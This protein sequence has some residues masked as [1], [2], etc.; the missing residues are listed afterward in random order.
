M[1]GVLISKDL[2]L[3]TKA[4][5]ENVPYDEK[6]LLSSNAGVMSGYLSPVE[7][8]SNWTKK[9]NGGYRAR[10]KRLWFDAASE[11]YKPKANDLE[12]DLFYPL[13]SDQPPS[14]KGDRLFA[15][16]RG[17]W[18]VIAIPN[19]EASDPTEKELFPVVPYV[20]TETKTVKVDGQ[21]VEVS[22]TKTYLICPGGLANDK[23]IKAVHVFCVESNKS[24]SDKFG[25]LPTAMNNFAA[26]NIDGKMV[27]CPGNTDLE[28]IFPTQIYDFIAKEWTKNNGKTLL[29]GCPAY[30]FFD[31]ATGKNRVICI[32]GSSAY[33]VSSP[34]SV[35]STAIPFYGHTITP[36]WEID[37][38][39]G[40]VKP[41][42]PLRT[43]DRSMTPDEYS[44]AAD[45]DR[46]F[47]KQNFS[48]IP[49]HKLISWNRGI[50]F[51]S[52]GGTE[53]LNAFPTATTTYF[54]DDLGTYV[55]S[56]NNSH[57]NVET[58]PDSPISLGECGAVYVSRYKGQSVNWLVAIGGRMLMQDGNYKLHEFPYV[59]DL[60]SNRWKIGEIPPLPTPRF[61]AGISQVVTTTETNPQ[62]NEQKTS[63]RIFVI[64]GRTQEGLTSKIES[65]NLTTGQWE[66]S[67]K[68]L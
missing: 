34:I 51:I 68:N 36:K 24:V 44:N 7:I 17:R 46:K 10:A 32:G 65:L 60:D 49:F 2:A 48:G 19:G 47:M 57:D 30:S 39:S 38:Q 23:S 18:E 37:L 9:E 41:M 64:A 56:A 35:Y 11:T 16:F 31:Q 40:S 1:K 67:W 14:A 12:V 42:P 22:E 63:D 20:T 66:T 33:Y 13:S 58:L 50:D 45:K 55:A 62:T 52:I 26:V 21:D 61:N 3:R 28:T 4:H 8:T 27:C 6:V 53:R 5:I 43:V 54:T 59:L 25:K 15:V 29:A